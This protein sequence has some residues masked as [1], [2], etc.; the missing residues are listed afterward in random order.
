[1]ASQR[2]ALIASGIALL[3]A[4]ALAG[5]FDPQQPEGQRYSMSPVE[6][7]FLRLDRETGTVSYCTVKEGVSACRASAEERETFEAELSRLRQE[8]AELKSRLAAVPRP[9]PPPSAVPSEEEM[10]RALSFTERF[11]RRIMRIFREEA[12]GEKS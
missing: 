4:E 11:M 10:E 5:T 6:G 3:S 2:L 9:P 8:N 1:M 7:G 12:P